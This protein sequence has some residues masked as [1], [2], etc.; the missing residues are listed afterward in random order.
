MLDRSV[1]KEYLMEKLE[2]IDIPQ[3]ITIDDLVEAFCQFVEDDYYEWIKDNFHSFFNY[4]KPDWN[5]IK[6]KINYYKN[7]S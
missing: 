2:V 1:I 5:W 6:M 4:Y 7:S 3:D